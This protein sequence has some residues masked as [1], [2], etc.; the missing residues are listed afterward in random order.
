[1]RSTD[2]FRHF[3]DQ[4]P[5]IAI[6][7]GITPD[8]VEAIGHAILRSGIRVIEVPLNSPQPLKSIELL[9]KKFGDQLLVGAGTVLDPGEV[10]RV[11]S[12]GGRIIVSPNINEQ[13][14]MASASAGLI[15]CPG[16]FTPTEAFRAIR[17]GANGLKLFPA[18]GATPKVLGAQ[19]AVLPKDVPILIVGGVKPETMRPWVDAGASGFGLGTGLYKPGQSAEETLDKARAYI[20]ALKR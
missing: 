20:S 9:A 8:D 17:A 18:E 10:E 16:F 19:L 15:S 3:L 13:V 14:I 7:R 4:C 11:K 6:V 5:L 12:V 1:M 2:L